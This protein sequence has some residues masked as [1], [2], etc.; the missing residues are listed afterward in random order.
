MRRSWLYALLALLVVLSIALTGWLLLF[1]GFALLTDAV[2][3]V[4]DRLLDMS[5]AQ[6]LWWLAAFALLS[7]S[8]QLLVV[9]S[10]SLLLIV[11][12]F[13]FGV[14]PS[15]LLFTFMQCAAV[16]PIYLICRSGSRRLRNEWFG[17]T[18]AAEAIRSEPL[19]SSMVLRLTPILP[20]AGASTI[21]ALSGITLQ[22]F[23]LATVLVGWIR[24]LFF[25]SVGAAV[26]EIS[27]LASAVSGEINPA[28]LLLVFLAVAGLFLVRLW[29]RFRRRSVTDS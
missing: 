3:A 27:G 22:T 10:G 12:G 18:P 13:V 20:S 19:V 28:P 11:A 8:L 4:A 7:F 14:V 5:Q 24:P 26:S 16:W 15:V 9:P 25:A 6:R 29:L 2:P 21:A 1:D 23:L 17:H